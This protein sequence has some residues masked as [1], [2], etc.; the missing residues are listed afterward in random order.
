MRLKDVLLKDRMNNVEVI[1]IEKGDL[2]RW[3]FCLNCGLPLLV[4]QLFSRL[5][6]CGYRNMQ[7]GAFVVAAP[8]NH[9]NLV[10]LSKIEMGTTSYAEHIRKYRERNLFNAPTGRKVE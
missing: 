6:K 10:R 8:V 5:C 1:P 2:F 3:I 7:H 4:K 9:K